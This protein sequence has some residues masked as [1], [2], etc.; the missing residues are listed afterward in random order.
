MISRRVFLATPLVLLAAERKPNVVLVIAAGWRGFAVP[1]N[2]DPDLQ[3][4]NLAKFGENAV[5][6]PRA[7]ACDPQNG[8]ARAGIMTG[9]FPH[10]TGA[11]DDGSDLRA[12]EVTLDAV[13]KLAGYNLLVSGDAVKANG[14]S[15]FFLKVILTAPPDTKPV[16]GARLHLRDN[17]PPNMHDEARDQMAK[18]YGIWAEMDRQFGAV[19]AAIDSV[20]NN[21]MVIFTSDHGEQLGSHGLEDAEV[22]YEES[23]R[24]PLAIRFPR[25]LKG[26]ASDIL[27]SQ[28]DILPTVLGLCGE[29]LFEGIQGHDLSPLLLTDKGDRPESIFGEGRIGKRDGW[30]MVVV[31]YDK[32]VVDSENAVTH[33][34]NLASD[35]YE[36]KNLADDAASRLKRDGLLAALRAERQK[37][38]D[39]SRR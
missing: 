21:T 38:L 19:L 4:P 3:A 30:R 29:P 18:A 33:L 16:D 14:A 2:G 25:V 15:P 22:P 36:M 35:P 12:E 11:T 31:G 28:V 1:W 24:I 8:P 27:A 20:A 9:R 6:F 37:L 17:V 5:V 39:F 26:A 13:L 10:I 34:Y 7:Y 23:A 32:L